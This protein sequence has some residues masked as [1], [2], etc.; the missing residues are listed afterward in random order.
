MKKTQENNGKKC[1]KMEYLDIEIYN[2]F[3]SLLLI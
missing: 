1:S 3:K 2:H